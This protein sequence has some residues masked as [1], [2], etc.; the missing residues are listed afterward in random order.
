MIMR[1]KIGIPMGIFDGI[2]HQ[3]GMDPILFNGCPDVL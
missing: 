3:F 2:K 1:S